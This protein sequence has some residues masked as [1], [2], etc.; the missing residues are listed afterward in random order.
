MTCGYHWRSL[1]FQ[2]DH[3]CTLESGHE[4]DHLDERFEPPARMR[5]TQVPSQ[6]LAQDEV[7]ALQR[8]LVVAGSPTS[9]D[10][11]R[12]TLDELKLAATL[13]QNSGGEWV[14]A[15]PLVDAVRL[16]ARLRDARSG[17]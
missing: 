9:Q 1:S 13:H 16:F 10:E 15:V 12:K 5:V 11:V 14:Y 7:T 8:A 2:R 3:E 17:E 6:G 4:D